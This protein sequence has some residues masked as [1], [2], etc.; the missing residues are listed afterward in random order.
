MYFE[1]FVKLIEYFGKKQR[2]KLGLFFVMALVAGLLE[3]LGIALIYPFVV[4]IVNPDAGTKYSAYL[5]QVIQNLSPIMMALTVGLT[6]MTIFVLKNLYMILYMFIQ[7]RFL[8]NWTQYV[9]NM[10]MDYFLHAPYLLIQKISD[11]EKFYIVNTL[12]SQATNGFVMRILTLV[13][14]AIIV[15]FVVGL[16]LFKFFTAG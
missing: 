3:F 6:A 5:P 12:A 10:I 8:Q 13:T 11:S 16:I 7:S 9:N 1:N 15:I 2:I 14:N 4:L